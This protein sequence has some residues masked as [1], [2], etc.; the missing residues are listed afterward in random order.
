MKG[1]RAQGKEV[2]LAWQTVA[3]PVRLLNRHEVVAI[4]GLTYPSIWQRMKR[5]EFPRSRVL[6]ERSVWRSDEIDQWL[7]NLPLRPLMGDAGQE[8][9]P[10][11]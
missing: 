9:T 4:T 1:K 10:A 3:V 6:G 7:A 8:Q 2:A 11:G 5:G